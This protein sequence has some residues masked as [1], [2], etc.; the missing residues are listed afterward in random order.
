MVVID[1]VF[2]S[3]GQNEL[4]RLIN[5]LLK[6]KNSGISVL[7]ACHQIDFMK[8]ISD[9]YIILRKG[10]TIRTF[11]REDF[12][13][14]LIQKLLVGNE[15]PKIKK[16]KSCIEK[17]VVFEMQNISGNGYIKD[18]SIKIRKGEILG[19][20]DLENKANKN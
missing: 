18:F 19:F 3:Y 20:Y 7:Y 1:D 2:Q 6:M 5:L 14:E 15:V 13:Q 11:Y 17:K 8:T 9:R 16:R 4:S 10:R 12:D